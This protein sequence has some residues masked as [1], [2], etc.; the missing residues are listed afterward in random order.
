MSSWMLMAV[1]AVASILKSVLTMRTTIMPSVSFI[2]S[3]YVYIN[4]TTEPYAEYQA[5]GAF[6]NMLVQ[7]SNQ[8]E[9]L[10][11]SCAS[12]AYRSYLSC[13]ATDTDTLKNPCP[14]TFTSPCCPACTVIP[15]IA[16]VVYFPVTNPY[17]NITTMVG[18]DGYTL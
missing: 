5:S 13:H 6:W 4:S 17:P 16:H 7:M 3:S 2:N 8:D 9:S 1:C 18:T 11:T 14:H 15:E 12:S 10:A